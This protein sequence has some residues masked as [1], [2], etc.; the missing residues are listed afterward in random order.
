MIID[1]YSYNSVPLSISKVLNNCENYRVEL[2]P[3]TSGVVSDIPIIIYTH[4]LNFYKSASIKLPQT[5][6]KVSHIKNKVVVSSC[7]FS[8][9]SN[10]LFIKGFIKKTIYYVPTNL[11]S[12]DSLK[13]YT[14]HIPFEVSTNVKINYS[15]A[16]PSTGRGFTDTHKANEESTFSYMDKSLPSTAQSSFNK[17]SNEFFYTRPYCE[18]VKITISENCRYIYI[19]DTD[20]NSKIIASRNIASLKDHMSISL[21]MIILQNQKI[22]ISPYLTA[23]EATIKALEDN[24][25]IAKLHSLDKP[26]VNDEC[27]WKAFMDSIDIYNSSTGTASISKPIS[28]EDTNSINPVNPTKSVDLSPESIL[29]ALL[30][31]G[32]IPRTYTFKT[33]FR[34]PKDFLSSHYS[35]TSYDVILLFLFILILID[36]DV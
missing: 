21:D 35:T 10:A 11:L 18:L 27:N 5:A 26:L 24:N 12:H 31:L 13:N 19:G 30:G 22:Y 8:N 14:T 34:H 2:N 23:S 36:L 28:K 25:F 6:S 20:S 1:T 9:D 33:P 29:F 15:K 17:V 16:V 32:D 4:R 3:L 7:I